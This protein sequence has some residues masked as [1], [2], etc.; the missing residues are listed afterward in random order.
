MPIGLDTMPVGLEIMSVGLDSMAVGLDIMPVALYV[1][2]SDVQYNDVYRE[3]KNPKLHTDKFTQTR[4]SQEM[5]SNCGISLN[6][7]F[8]G[9][10]KY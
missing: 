5:Q 2:C 4:T 1:V 10:Q 7:H 9:D 8:A 6:K 3:A